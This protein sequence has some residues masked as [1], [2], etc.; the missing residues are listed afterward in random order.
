MIDDILRLKFHVGMVGGTRVFSSVVLCGKPIRDLVLWILWDLVPIPVPIL[1]LWNLS[2][3]VPRLAILV[4]LN[5]LIAGTL[6]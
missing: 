1:C 6:I 3:L 2:L 4:L 5:L